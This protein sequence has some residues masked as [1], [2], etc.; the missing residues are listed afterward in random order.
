V[1]EVAFAVLPGKEARRIVHVGMNW[2]PCLTIPFST[3]YYTL[4]E[5]LIS[6]EDP[7]LLA[8]HIVTPRV[9]YTDQA[10]SRAN[11]SQDI[12]HAGHEAIRGVTKKWT[13]KRKK[14]E[15]DQKR[16]D[17]EKLEEIRRAAQREMSAKEASWLVMKEA[18]AHVTGNRPSDPAHARQIMYAVRKR[19]QKHTSKCWK[20]SSTFT[21]RY[22]P[23]FQE[24]HPQ[25]TAARYVV[26]DARGHYKEPHTDKRVEL[27]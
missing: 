8:V 5:V 11:F 25:D 2:T 26:Y 22:L 14:E 13:A 6:R 15:R 23:E 7:V 3:L 12:T 18:H 21:Q 24:K 1:V 17:E 16:I 9:P 4:D 19:M 10:K 27:G 20:K